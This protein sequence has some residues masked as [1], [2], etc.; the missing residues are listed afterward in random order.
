MSTLLEFESSKDS[1]FLDSIRKEP[2]ELMRRLVCLHAVLL[3]FMLLKPYFCLWITFLWRQGGCS[4]FSVSVTTLTQYWAILGQH[5][6]L[7]HLL[8]LIRPNVKS[9][10]QRTSRQKAKQDTLPQQVGENVKAI[11]SELSDSSAEYLLHLV[12][13]YSLQAPP[14]LLH[15]L[16]SSRAEVKFTS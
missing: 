15:L 11:F 9:A 16:P 8:I 3:C 10:R 6:L 14:K 5:I 7:T 12:S 13:S 1:A 2:C 4:Y